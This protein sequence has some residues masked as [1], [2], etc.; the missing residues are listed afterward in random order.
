MNNGKKTHVLLYF[1]V[2]MFLFV[3]GCSSGG[4]D[5]ATSSS[6]STF[7][8]S[9]LTGTWNF[10][11]FQTDG[12]SGWDRGTITIDSNGSVTF[13]SFEDTR[14]GSTPA[15]GSVIGTINSSGTITMS[16]TS[17]DEESHCSMSTDKNT[18]VCVI[19]NG[20]QPSIRIMVKK[21]GVTFSNA[22]LTGPL[23][24]NIHGI[25]SGG[26]SASDRYWEYRAG[27]INASRQVTLTQYENPAGSQTL[28]SANFTTFTVGADGFVT[29][30]SD[31]TFK[32]MLS[33]DKKMMVI[34]TRDGGSPEIFGLGIFTIADETFTGTSDLA[35]TWHAFNLY[36]GDNFGWTLVTATINSSGVATVSSYLDSDGN[37]TVSGS[38]SF[39][40]NTSGIISD[41]DNATYH[42]VLSHD[43]IVGV[44]TGAPGIYQ[45]DF[46]I[47]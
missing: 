34:T 2:L 16:G 27:T 28:P 33:S 46:F 13:T 41:S 42:G 7:S 30:A 44:D 12:N 36:G 18:V 22:D 17:A 29:N 45:I 20:T 9:D 43:R 37:T 31:S 47:K 32:G 3:S 1:L 35:G 39:T 25:S 6:S 15:A 11:G 24:F 26:S 14:G 40:M 19:T 23:S 38:R 10:T 5:S 8:Q 21:T 4:G